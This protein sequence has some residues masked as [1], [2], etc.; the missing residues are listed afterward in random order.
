MDFPDLSQ[1]TFFADAIGRHHVQTR[2]APS[3]A[4]LHHALNRSRNIFHR[5]FLH[6]QGANS[7]GC[8]SD[9]AEQRAPRQNL[10]LCLVECMS[11][12][13]SGTII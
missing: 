7:V 1:N 9:G 8:L 12:K 2:R 3:L 10:C 11:L 13:Q 4:L 5:F 6:Q